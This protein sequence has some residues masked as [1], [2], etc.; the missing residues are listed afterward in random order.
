MYGPFLSERGILD[1][2]LFDLVICLV[3]Y[4]FIWGSGDNRITN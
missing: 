1:V 4:L 2:E 3:G